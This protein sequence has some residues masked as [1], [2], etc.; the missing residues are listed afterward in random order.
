M[1]DP[2][3]LTNALWITPAVI[4]LAI[5]AAMV[6]RHLWRKMPMF[7]L[8]T[9]SHL[10]RFLLLYSVFHYGSYLAYFFSY[11]LAEVFDA[12]MSLLVIRE[13]YGNI[14]GR[15]EQ[16]DRLSSVLFTWAL[17]LL[18]GVATVTAAASTGSESSRILQG[19]FAFD[20]AKSILAGG[21]LLLL[22]ALSS[23]LKLR[24]QD[25]LLGVAIGFSMY[26]AVDLLCTV[27]RIRLGQPSDLVAQVQ[28]LSY[29]C[30]TIV[31][32]VYC[33]RHQSE[34]PMPG[35]VSHSD[36]ERWNQ[37]LAQFV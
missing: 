31:W 10:V 12:I 17:A 28:S 37:E 14:F 4:Q 32:V 16:L 1:A 36:L 3:L 25:A 7:L 33:L 5:T 18:L 8:Y 35:A 30:A 19:V 15:Y 11:W 22:F 29:D 13:L 24:W 34:V 26:A 27:W 2:D 23:L 21:L 6:S 20:E 9:V